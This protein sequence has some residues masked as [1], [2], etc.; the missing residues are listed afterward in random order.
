MRIPLS[1]LFLSSIH[2]FLSITK[3]QVEESSCSTLMKRSFN[4][5]STASVEE[6]RTPAFEELLRLFRKADSKEKING[7][8]NVH[9]TTGVLEAT[10]ES[11]DSTLPF[12]C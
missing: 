3:S 1:V 2:V 12:N 11:L 6:L 8:G 5:P 4:L 10:L 7:Y 9:N